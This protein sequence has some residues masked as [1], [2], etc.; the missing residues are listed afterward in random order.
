MELL[1]PVGN[2]DNLIAAVQN[3]ADAVYL[4]ADSFNARAGAQNFSREELKN[5][6]MYARK[7][8][9]DVHLTLN[10]LMFNNEINEALDVAKFAYECGISAI[11]VQDIGLATELVKKFPDLPIHSSTQMTISNIYGVKQME[12]L[13]LKRVVLARE[14]SLKEISDIRQNTKM[15]LETFGHGALCVSYS[16]QCL[17]S[18]IVGKRSGN[19]GLCAGPCRLNYNLLKNGNNIEEGYLLSTK[20]ICTLQ[21]LP[22]LIDAGIDSIKIEG[23]KKSYEYV[24]IITKIYRKYIDLAK[25]KTKEYK[26]DENDLKEILQIYNRGGMGTGYFENR[27]NIVY[28]EKPNHL[29]IY[30]GDVKKVDIKNKQIKIDLTDEVFL[31]D[32]ISVNNETSYV[33]QIIENNTVGE[34]KNTKNIH[35]GDEVYK[36]VSKT[37]NKQQ[38][39][40]Y[41]KEIRKVD[42]N[43]KLYKNEVGLN[44]ELSNGKISTVSCIELEEFDLKPLENE[45][46]IVQIKKTGNTIFNIENIKIEVEELSVPVSKIN[47]LRRIAIEDFEKALEESIVRKYTDNN[48]CQVNINK[49][50]VPKDIRINLYMQKWDSSR[51]NISN[52]KYN[53][54]YVQFKDLVNCD[55]IRDCVAVL[56][57]ILDETYEKLI[58]NN[59]QVFEKVKAVMISHIS[60]VEFLKALGINKKIYADYKINITN[61]VSEKFIKDLGIERFTVSPELDKKGINE[62]ETN[63]E[64]EAVVYGRI[65]LMTSKY[66]PIGKNENCNGKCKNAI[67]ELRDRKNFDFP[68]LTDRTNCHS[69]IYNSK[70][71]S[72]EYKKLNIDY[73]RIDIFNETAEE[74][75]D[76]INK[77][78]QNQKFTG[79]NYT[80]GNF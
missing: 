80:N 2:F 11:I 16:G 15:E 52:L 21:I 12:K 20:D 69:E 23:R 25:D 74:I 56:P 26:V 64:K 22:Q 72:A 50:V 47:N 29:G 45:R 62:F 49:N 57:T 65:C 9:V 53:E 10:I 54:V 8:G 43:A 31:G 32:V 27:Q 79:K 36:I 77:V 66:C 59:L 60:Q 75:E 48:H 19:R 6:I 67:Y 13:G 1:S 44:L 40:I 70:V 28:K 37:L 35:V 61:N 14:L 71:I 55:E 30:I 78:K 5:A 34:I 41:K 73:A 18:S 4:G 3:G 17:F 33:S 39:E 46:I 63:I 42:I 58:K 68:I 51:N 76:I 24:S 7:R 38:W